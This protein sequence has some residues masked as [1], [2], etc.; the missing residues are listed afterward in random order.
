MP[1][2]VVMKNTASF[3]VR[4]GVVYNNECCVVSGAENDKGYYEGYYFNVKNA[5]R[6]W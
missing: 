5:V 2:L 6:F 1:H 4:S 3:L